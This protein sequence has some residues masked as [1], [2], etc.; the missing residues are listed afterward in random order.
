MIELLANYTTVVIILQYYKHIKSNVIHLK[1]VQLYL[2]YI[3]I[4][5]KKITGPGLG[6]NPSPATRKLGDFG[7]VIEPV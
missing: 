7:Q 3:S 1:V 5:K 2:N 4:L 6:S